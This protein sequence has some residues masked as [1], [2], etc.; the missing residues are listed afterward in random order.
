MTQVA[1]TLDDGQMSERRRRWHALAER[2]V[3]DRTETENGLRLAFRNEAGVADELREL[4]AL[5]RTCC[6]FADWSVRGTVL[7]VTGTGDEG[8]AA[9]HGMFRSLC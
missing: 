7:E 1:C 4:A 6:A 9:V 2:A 5:E 3:A 8:I